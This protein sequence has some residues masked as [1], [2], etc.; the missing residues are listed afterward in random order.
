MLNEF[1]QRVWACLQVGGPWIA[2][3]CVFLLTRAV[4]RLLPGICWRGAKATAKSEA[5]FCVLVL[6]AM[7]A[8][9]SVGFVLFWSASQ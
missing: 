2:I 3:A 7:I 8:L 4:L 9:A 5:P 6:M 1:M